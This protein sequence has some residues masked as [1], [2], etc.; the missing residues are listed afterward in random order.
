[1]SEK[2]K[3]TR[4][5]KGRWIFRG[6]NESM[7]KNYKK[8]GIPIGT[9]FTTDPIMAKK[10]GKQLIAIPYSKSLK[11]SGDNSIFKRLKLKERYFLTQRKRKKF[12]EVGMI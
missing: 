7:F 8:K 10:H 6:V 12:I 3:K 4:I 9:V 5:E 11:E 2:N 1:M